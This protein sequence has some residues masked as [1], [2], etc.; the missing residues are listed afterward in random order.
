M[1]FSDTSNED[2]GA[3]SDPEPL[4]V[5]LGFPWSA[6]RNLMT[7]WVKNTERMGKSLRS[8]KGQKRRGKKT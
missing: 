1:D 6:S 7:S 4:P 3:P 8:C 2:G 5:L